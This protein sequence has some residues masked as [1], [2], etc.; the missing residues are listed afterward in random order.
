MPYESIALPSIC[1]LSQIDLFYLKQGVFPVSA[2]HSPKWTFLC[3]MNHPPNQNCQQSPAS[4][5]FIIYNDAVNRGKEPSSG[6]GIS[7]AY[8]AGGE[9]HTLHFVGKVHLM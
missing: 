9:K 7:S 8:S 1:L 2:P 3:L 5:I 6:P 4:R